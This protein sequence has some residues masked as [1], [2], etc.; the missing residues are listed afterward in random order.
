MSNASASRVYTRLELTIHD[1]L[2]NTYHHPLVLTS[3]CFLR[4]IAT[5]LE[6][7]LH[8]TRIIDI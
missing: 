2:T 8:A 7:N 3:M 1:L 5:E 6:Q 4:G